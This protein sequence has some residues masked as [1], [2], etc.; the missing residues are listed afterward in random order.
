V[1]GL[2][3]VSPYPPP[4]DGIGAHTRMLAEA[5]RERVDVAVAAPGAAAPTD[6]AGG[7]H[8]VLGRHDGAARAALL[9]RCRPDAVF[10]Q[11]AI[12]AYGAALPGLDHLLRLARRRGIRVLTVFHEP[13]R[14]AA[15]LP[16]VAAAIY[17]RVA[18]F[19]DTPIVLAEPAREGL[20]AAG[21]DARAAV[22]VP[23]GVP[24]LPPVSVFDVERVRVRYGLRGRIVLALGFV[25]PDKGADVLAGAAPV[26]L[27]QVDDAT[28]VIAGEPRQRHGLFRVFGRADARHLDALR[29]ATAWA[30]DR[31]RFCGFVAD[32]DLPA[33]LAAATAMVL[34]YRRITQSGIAQLCVAGTV[35][36]V[37]SRLPGLE[38]TLGDGA[39]YVPPD[40]PDALAAALRRVLGDR[41]LRAR[42]RAALAERRT[43]WSPLIVADRILEVALGDGAARSPLRPAASR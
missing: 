18:S 33:V 2:L 14:D 29:E 9:D 15:A 16:G 39:V 26:L 32:E 10:V 11:F 36:A 37:A 1:S 20:E 27:P 22:A 31:I 38:A 28:I 21:I 43:A 7:V 41:V 23:L 3:L 4:A 19:T 17:R 8:R 42:Q 24:A 12:A 34:P 30:G 5:L 35:P 25:H 13:Q 40:D 6:A